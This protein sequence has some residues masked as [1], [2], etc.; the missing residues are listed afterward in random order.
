[1]SLPSIAAAGV[2][3]AAVA[4]VSAT[5]AT[6]VAVSA[7]TTRIAISAT[8]AVSFGFIVVCPHNYRCFHCRCLPLLLPMLSAV[9]AVAT[10]LVSMQSQPLLL[11]PPLLPLFPRTSPLPPKQYFEHHPGERSHALLLPLT[12]AIVADV[13]PAAAAATTTTAIS[14][15]IAAPFWLTVVSFSPFATAALVV[16]EIW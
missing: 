5:I 2:S 14:S 3:A 7:V 8:I 10:V 15:T 16:A 13:D 6:A 9:A 1:L 12:I 11:P 4:A